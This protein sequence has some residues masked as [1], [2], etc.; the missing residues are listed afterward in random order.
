MYGARIAIV[1]GNVENPGTILWASPPPPPIVPG[2]TID[3]EEV[4]DFY[5]SLDDDGSLTVYRTREIEKISVIGREFLDTAE[6]WWS[7]L[8]A[9]EPSTPPMT[10][11]GENWKAFQRWAKLKT[12][13]KPTVGRSERK[14]RQNENERVI[15]E[16]VYATSPAGCYAAG[17]QVINISKTIKRSV[18]KVV[19][20]LDDR[21]GGIMD[22]LHEGSEDDIDLL[23]TF[24]RIVLTGF[25]SFTTSGLRAF[26]RFLPKFMDIISE[27]RYKFSKYSRILR[28][29]SRDYLEN[30]KHKIKNLRRVI[31]K[32]IDQMMNQFQSREYYL[33]KSRHKLR[34]LR[35]VLQKKLDQMM[36]QFEF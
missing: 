1:V 33:E 9:G 11:A 28:Y 8:V 27:G 4:I 34:D 30:S 24:V 31:R 17:R 2:N 26:K 16:C 10:R 36:S 13:G 6:K 22:S 12:T 19:S 20:Q 18:E 25:R 15:D 21:V 14:A 3:E 35:N 5:C 32:K 29:E 7:D 23:D